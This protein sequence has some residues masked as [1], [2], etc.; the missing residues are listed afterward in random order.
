MAAIR[1]ASE[2]ARVG[3]KAFNATLARRAE[4]LRRGGVNVIGVDM[5]ELF[6]E[7]LADPQ[8][9][10]VANATAPCLVPPSAGGPGSYCGAD[11]APLLAFFDP[12]HPNATI[13]A[14]IADRVRASVVPVPLPAPAALLLV[15]LGGLALVRMRGR[16]GS[17]IA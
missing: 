17:R 3:T 10:G 5:F 13:H 16:Q 8:A 15:A 6:N 2:Q 12:V 4:G 14:Q 9:F 7:L 11:V 1:L